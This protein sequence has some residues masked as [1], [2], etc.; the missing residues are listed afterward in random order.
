MSS[1][2]HLW[3]KVEITLTAERVCWLDLRTSTW[4]TAFALQANADGELPYPSP[5]KTIRHRN[6]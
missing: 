2:L 3:E 4:G 6:A 1:P 5:T